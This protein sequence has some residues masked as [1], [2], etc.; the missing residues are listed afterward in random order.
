VGG[1]GGE[2]V[3]RGSAGVGRGLRGGGG[4]GR[5][6]DRGGRAEGG[7][8]GGEGEGEG[9]EEGEGP[10]GEG[11][12]GERGPAGSRCP[13]P[14]PPGAPCGGEARHPGWPREQPE[15]F[16]ACGSARGAAGVAEI[17]HPVKKT[18]VWLGTFGTRRVGRKGLRRGRHQPLRGQ[19]QAQRSGA[20]ALRRVTSH[21]SVYWTGTVMTRYSAGAV[22][23]S[24]VQC[25]AVQQG[26]G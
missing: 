18:R 15:P 19:G 21:K 17:R 14:R 26:R 1:G 25:S 23:C 3:P 4:G 2:G 9:E 5:G 20:P 24:A 22:Q 10:E 6:R 8:G 11:G 12:A 7:E 13:T 16:P